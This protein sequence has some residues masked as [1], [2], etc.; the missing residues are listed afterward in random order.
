ME[1]KILLLLAGPAGVGKRPLVDALKRTLEYRKV[2]VF[3]VPVLTGRPVVRDAQVP[4]M[5]VVGTD[6]LTAVCSDRYAIETVRETLNAV[7]LQ[8]VVEVLN[9][10]DVVI[11]VAYHTLAQKVAERAGVLADQ[12]G[13]RVLPVFLSPFSDEEI[14]ACTHKE[15]ILPPIMHGRQLERAL[16]EAV[17]VRRMVGSSATAGTMIRTAT[18]LQ[19]LQARTQFAHVL[20]LRNGHLPE[21]WDADPPSGEAGSALSRLVELIAGK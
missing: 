14:S 10:Y 7:D 13:L 18:L 1:N 15:H 17:S 19:E 2:T 3:E 6:E 11:V 12:N 4:G 9:K 21:V 20:T 5:R 8:E 16:R